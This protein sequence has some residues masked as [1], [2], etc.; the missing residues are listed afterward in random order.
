MEH[1]IFFTPLEEFAKENIR[2]HLE[3]GD[4]GDEDFLSK[5]KMQ[6][7]IL[8][9]ELKSGLENIDGS[10]NSHDGYELPRIYWESSD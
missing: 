7:E 5:V 1:P 6:L 4:F 3:V 8:D 9:K 10:E 2:Y